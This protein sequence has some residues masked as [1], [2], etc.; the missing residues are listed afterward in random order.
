MPSSSRDSISA[1]AEDLFFANLHLS[2]EEW[3]GCLAAGCVG[4]IELTAKMREELEEL[5]AQLEHVSGADQPAAG[6][7]GGYP[8]PLNLRVTGR[9]GCQYELVRKI[10]TG[11]HSTVYEAIQREPL[12]GRSPSRCITPRQLPVTGWENSARFRLSR[13]CSIRASAR[14][15]TLG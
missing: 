12:N 15:S 13:G 8:E 9:Q 5:V 4:S 11:G 14:S 6:S 7:D 2:T 3:G 1:E 10:G